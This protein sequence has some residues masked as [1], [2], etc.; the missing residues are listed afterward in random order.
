[1]RYGR[2][3]D[4]LEVISWQ[5]SLSR[6]VPAVAGTSL[7]LS[8]LPRRICQPEPPTGFDHHFQ[9]MA[10]LAY[11]V[12]PSRLCRRTDGTGILNLF[13]ISYAFRPRLR[14]R[15]TLGGR[16]IPRKSWDFGGRDSH[17]AYRYSCP[18][19]H[20][21]GV[22]V[23]LPSRFNR[24]GTLP[25]HEPRSRAVHPQRRH[26]VSVPIIYGARPLDWSAVT[27]CLNDGCL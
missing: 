22:H 8:E 17:P 24:H 3:S 14:G 25:Y 15:L 6:S 2:L 21:H 23:R 11:C 10:G 20:F 18:H 16:T 5:P 7:R 27:H 12:T 19:N 4:S 26:P 9:S 13:P 1:M